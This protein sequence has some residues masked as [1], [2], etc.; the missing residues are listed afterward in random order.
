[1]H[2]SRQRAEC[3]RAGRADKPVLECHSRLLDVRE[4]LHK[5][6]LIGRTPQCAEGTNAAAD[7]E[8]RGVAVCL[9]T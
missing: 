6:G 5:Q 4:V 2:R 3:E 9:T 8:F 1:L 7:L